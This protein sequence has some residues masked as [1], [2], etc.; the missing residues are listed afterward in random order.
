[1][2]NQGKVGLQHTADPVPTRLSYTPLSVLTYVT[3]P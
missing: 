1:M 2:G 3:K